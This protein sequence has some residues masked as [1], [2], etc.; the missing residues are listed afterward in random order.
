MDTYH[1]RVGRGLTLA[2]VFVVGSMAPQ[3]YGDA[4]LVFGDKTQETAKLTS[5]LI[6][7][8]HIDLSV[9]T[10]TPLP[11]EVVAA[12]TEADAAAVLFFLFF[13]DGMQNLT[14]GIGNGQGM[15]RNHRVILKVGSDHADDDR[16]VG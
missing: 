3:A 9:T 6:G 8:G 4:V 10:N 1:G 15:D 2:V 11:G 12:T 7:L 16:L 13:N 14:I 5:D